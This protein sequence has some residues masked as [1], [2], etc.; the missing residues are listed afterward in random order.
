MERQDDYEPAL[1]PKESGAS[2]REF[3]PVAFFLLQPFCCP[4]FRPQTLWCGGQRCAGAR[5]HRLGFLFIY[6]ID[7]AR[8]DGGRGKFPTRGRDAGSGRSTTPPHH[9]TRGRGP[10]GAGLGRCSAG[11]PRAA[12]P[13]PRTAASPRLLLPSWGSAGTARQL[14]EPPGALQMC[15]PSPQR[16][17]A[18]RR[19]GGR[20]GSPRRS[21][22]PAPRPGE[23]A[24]AAGER[25]Q[26]SLQILVLLCIPRPAQVPRRRK[27]AYPALTCG[28]ARR[29]AVAAGRERSAVRSG[30]C[31]VAGRPRTE[32]GARPSSRGG[33]GGAAGAGPDVTGGGAG[34]GAWRGAA[35]RGRSRRCHGPAAQ[36]GCAGSGAD[37]A[38]QARTGGF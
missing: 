27:G 25:A 33:S 22:V 36:S 9:Q 30:R 15:Q 3:G 32:L 34:P 17:C 16:S 24:G 19:Q 23:A 35:A 8:R 7:A 1:L 20:A 38:P 21:A 2:R 37:V 14:G 18:P 6:L 12:L 31:A 4:S 26:T 11:P 28:E 29:E 13:P 5:T 10:S